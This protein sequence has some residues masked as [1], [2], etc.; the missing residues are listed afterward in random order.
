MSPL[1]AAM[2]YAQRGWRPIPLPSQSKKP[3]FRGWQRLFLEETQLSEYFNC[4]SQNIGILLGEPS[5]WLIDIDLDHPLAVQLGGEHLP[6]TPAVFGR[7]SKPRSH[8]LYYSTQPVDTSKFQ[9]PSTGMIVELRS[10]GAQTVFP[11]SIHE[12]GEL[13]EWG[14]TSEEPAL[15]DP[16]GLM[17][18]VALIAQMVRR[19]N[20]ASIVNRQYFDTFS[21]SN[22]SWPALSAFSS[23]KLEQCL[24]QMLRINTVDK[25]DGSNRLFAVACRAVEHG[26]ED[27]DSLT[28]IR[29]YI[30]QRPFRHSW[31]DQQ[32]LQRIRD[33][34]K[35]TSRGKASR[36]RILIDTDE[37]RVVNEAIKALCV[38]PE[39]YQRGAQLVRVLHGSLTNDG[40]E[41]GEEAPT[42]MALP[43]AAL[44]D[45]MTEHIAFV[46]LAKTGEGDVEVAAHPTSWLVGAV[47]ARG[48]WPGI[49]RLNGISDVPILRPDGSLW[50]T[51][52]YDPVTGVLFE[53]SAKFPQMS[54]DVNLDDADYAVNALMEIVCDFRFED[55]AHRAA[56]LSGLLTPIARFAFDGPSPLFLVDANVRG[57]G[58]GLLVQTIGWTVMGREMPVSSYSHDPEE[59]RKKITASALAGDR[60][61]HL[62]NLEGTF[63]NQALDRMLTSTRWKDRILGRS[64]LV[65]L[66]L[67]AVWYGTGNNVAVAADTTRRIIHIRL[68]VLEERPEERADFRHPNLISW[69]RENRPTL[70]M[71]A[72]TI[73]VAY[74]RAGCPRQTLPCFGSYEGWS[75][76]VREA[77]V[78]VG[79][80]DPCRTRTR[81]VELS[82]TTADG[83]CQLIQAWEMYIGVGAAMVVSELL[84]NLFSKDLV[85]SD[86]ALAM[87]SAIE[88]LVGCAAGKVPSNR[89]LGNKLRHF[90]R[91]VTK[92]MYIDTNPK[93]TSRNG[94]VWRLCAD[95]QRKVICESASLA[96]L[97]PPNP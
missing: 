39:L 44:R 80:P 70:L 85:L 30:R 76:I 53:P 47:D 10:T 25:N 54:D 13:I 96:S 52:G 66:P 73:L 60:L 29:E 46:K 41:R 32:I 23:P 72:L 86:E 9:S 15:V 26:L 49:R 37:H 35:K 97:I 4:N 88:N 20:G 12:S 34:E 40:V 74:F 31:S 67:H 91:R 3:N 58:K 22:N 56:W 27:A 75:R 14:G 81:F 63:G 90:R 17:A 42:I 83:L 50:Q 64:E 7:P 16:D 61:V 24:L 92:G 94:A 89:Q 1:E 36:P 59:M 57:A 6:P 95:A 28:V 8:W 77:I 45:K 87:R 62:D 68:D 71:H 79:L 78:W 55:D 65:E 2:K 18:A 11:P 51:P 33:A 43:Q 93:D 19:K 21:Q 84:P 69:I 48:D 5:G 82:D 38:A